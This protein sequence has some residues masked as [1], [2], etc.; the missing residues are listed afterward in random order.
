MMKLQKVIK[1]TALQLN[2]MDESHKYNVESKKS[3][4]M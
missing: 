1:M 4:F 2:N 3:E